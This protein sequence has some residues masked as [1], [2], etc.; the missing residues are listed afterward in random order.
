[1][2]PRRDVRALTVGIGVSFALTFVIKALEYR[3]SN[4]PHDPDKGP[5]IYYWV[6]PNPTAVTRLSAWS[7]YACHQVAHLALIYYAQTHVKETTTELHPVN[8]AALAVN[9]F[10]SVAH[11]VQTHTFYD[12][13]AQDVPELSA[14]GSVAILLIWVLLMENYTRGMI[15]GHPLPLSNEVVRFARKY[16]AYYFSWALIYNFWYH[17]MEATLG[18]LWGICYT[19]L[20]LLQG[21]LFFTK[22]HLNTWWKLVLKLIVAPHGM[23]IAL[24]QPYTLWPIFFFGCLSVFAITQMHIRE[25]GWSVKIATVL[26]LVVGC[27]F[28]YCNKPLYRFNEP[29]RVPIMDYV[30]VLLLT[31]ILYTILKGKAFVTNLVT[32]KAD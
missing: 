28:Y 6:L 12:G 19:F 15:A 1:M 3:L 21:S 20:L 32:K 10:F 18:H 23:I 7:L 9:L 22:I 31:G 26:V 30:G 16:H 29:L 11:I 17:P 14:L 25:I 24:N 8:C 5:F 27:I 4:V 2:S 13:L